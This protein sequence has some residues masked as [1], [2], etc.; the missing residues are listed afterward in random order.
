MRTT[1]GSPSPGILHRED[2]PPWLLE[3]PLGLTGGLGEAWTPLLRNMHVHEGLCTGLPLGQGREGGERTAPAAAKS[4]TTASVRAPAKLTPR[5][6][7][8]WNLGLPRPEEK[9]WLWDAEVTQS[10][11]RAWVRRQ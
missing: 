9:T 5:R 11:G 4:P 7:V 2:K 3:G 1:I 8:V 10:Q 6:S